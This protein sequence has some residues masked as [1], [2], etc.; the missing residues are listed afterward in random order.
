MNRMWLIAWHEYAMRVLKKG[1]LLAVAALPVFVIAMVG[2]GAFIESTERDDRPLGYVDVAG[3]LGDPRPPV[4]WAR[5]PDDV[6]A[7][8]LVPMA[9]F[10]SADEALA[11]LRRG[12]IQAY[13]VLAPDYAQTRRVELYYLKAPGGNAT[14]QFWSF[15]QVNQLGGLDPAVAERATAGSNLTVRWPEGTP[16]GAREFSPRTF[17]SNFLPMI[18]AMANIYV[19]ISTS[20]TLIEAL[21]TEKENRTI[22][23][24][25]TSVSTEQLVIGK[26]I[27]I[28]GMT[29]TLLAGWAALSV[30]AVWI[31]GQ[32]FHLAILQNVR[33]DGGMA[34]RML[35]VAIPS[36]VL[37][38]A[39]VVA[40]G[41][42]LSDAHE[43]QQTSGLFVLPSVA[44]F[45]FSM[46]IF[47][48]PA[49]P[50]LTILTMVPLTA[51]TMLALRLMLSAVPGWQ[52]AA[53]AAITALAAAGATWLAAR[54]FRLGLLRYGKK[55]S[56]REIMGRSA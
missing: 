15:L 31:G 18:L 8:R 11:A 29:L 14:R 55:L 50:I 44:P 5:G 33:V 42:T 48:N 22:E 40:L 54:A 23:I 21:V 46:L 27:G 24:M 12:E 13:Y 39:L 45:W 38:S 17:L 10:G 35:V 37:L 30:A 41:I 4:A 20:S 36:L 7:A 2:L 51:L 28:V 9:R 19:L 26:V 25:L 32:V 3:A 43:A 16:G 53:S 34:L 56:L 47:Q 49:S 1:F 52:V 6:G